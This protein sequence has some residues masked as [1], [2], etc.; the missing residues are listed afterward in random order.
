ML[1][2]TE[3]RWPLAAKVALVLGL[4]CP[5]SHAQQ[6][7][8][9]TA[10]QPEQS[11]Q[12]P[13]DQPTQ[14]T[15]TLEDL[16]LIGSDAA[17]PPIADSLGGAESPVRKAMWDKGMAVRLVQTVQYVQNTLQ[18]PVPADQQVYI[19]QH[20][21]EGA[22]EHVLFTA[23][24]RQLHLQ[25]AQLYA[26]GVWNWVSWNPAGPKAFQIWDLYL[27]KSLGNDR[28]QVKAGYISN[29]LEFVGL[30]VGG[31][32]GTAAQGVYATL[33][34]EVGLSYF[35]LT[36]PSLNVRLRG[37]GQTYV[38]FGAQRSLDPAGGPTEVARNRTGFR[39]LPHGDKLLEINEAGYQRTASS[40]AREAWLRVG[41]MRNSTPFV[42]LS[43]G[44]KES[45]N[46]HAF[47]LIDLQVHRSDALQPYKGLYLGLSA[48]TAASRFNPYDRYYEAR[49]YQKAP[50]RSRPGDMASLVASYI[51]H[52]KAALDPLRAAGKSVWS[53]S[54][55]LTGSYAIHV[56]QGQYLSLGLSYLRGAALTPRVPDALSFSAN[57]A[58]FF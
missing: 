26:S 25:H 44:R 51:G 5:M 17:M 11:A 57:Y 23:D 7:E 53:N 13:A 3:S 19:G 37:P 15:R 36:T 49:L 52:S 24:L 56:A 55:T 47:A 9:Q 8:Q 41:Y 28:L 32:T 42:N 16:N 48:M 12:Q 10:Q 1:F 38:K 50:F 29:G 46:D 33:P 14:P 20:P 18:A 2:K 6:A 43:S 30:L 34:Y 39:F 22:L 4:A 40:T 31:S 21:F 58:V 54:A 45:G 27:Y 35:P